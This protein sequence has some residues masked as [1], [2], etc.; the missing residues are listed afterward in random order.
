MRLVCCLLTFLV[1]ML[2]VILGSRP[3]VW[4]SSSQE[5]FL[6]G[7]FRG[8][9]LTSDGRLVQ[10]PQ[11]KLMFNTAQPFIYAVD[12]DQQGNILAGTGSEGK[13]YRVTPNGQGAELADFEQ[14]GVQALAVRPDGQVLAGTAPDG[15]VYRIAANGSVSVFFDPEEKYIWDLTLDPAGALFVATG[16]RGRIFKVNGQGRGEVFYDSSEEHIVD[17]TWDAQG[18]LLAGSSPAGLLISLNQ[19]GK[20]FVLFDSDLEEVRAINTDRYGNIY[21]VAISFSKAPPDPAETS[22]QAE[23][24]PGSAAPADPAGQETV[25]IEGIRKGSKIELFRVARDNLVDILYSAADRT[26]FDLLV[27]QNGEVLMGSGPQGRLLSITAAR[28][29]KVLGETPDEQVT[30]LVSA[31]NRITVAT[32]NLGK[33]YRL[34]REPGT[35]G[36]YESDVLDAG[37]VSE[38]GRIRWQVT[39]PGGDGIGFST[40]SGN[41]AKADDTWSEWAGVGEGA[42]GTPV[43]SPAARYLQWMVEFANPGESNA[44]LSERNGIDSVEVS[45]L[46]KN[47][48]PQITSVSV[49][50]PGSAFVKIPVATQLNAALGGPDDSH[51]RSLPP[52]IRSL[53]KAPV[54]PPRRIYTP[55]SRSVTWKATDRNGDDLAF[56]IYLRGK[57]DATWRLLKESWQE[58]FY[59]LDAAS[60]PDGVYTFRIV[61]SDRFS[62]P[63]GKAL[64]TEMISK[65]FTVANRLPTL[66]IGEP[67]VSEDGAAFQV[68]AKTHTSSVFQLEYSLDGRAWV[69][70]WPADGIADSDNE[71]YEIELSSLPQGRHS[72]LIR[73]IDSVGNL[74]SG[75]VGFTVR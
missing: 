24:P 42:T 34:S 41:T 48:A 70:A 26:V 39:R 13:L 33:L 7:T 2:P 57:S 36:T 49:H 6:K 50:A 27:R 28:L 32:S 10:A 20:P 51:L 55:A 29:K 61:A 17:L 37:V 69:I 1:A 73:V 11:I 5:D 44:L 52:S 47:I 63:P 9:A 12:V 75:S 60:V 68:T 15:K 30:R 53:K 58:T 43:P 22:T 19:S 56:D 59:T 4:R 67:R 71:T 25:Q 35:T 64:E 23:K 45:Y 46:Q 62:N 31:A 74:G 65:P 18:N 8:V 40:R 14:P 66:E 72:L 16:P 3:T 54:V 38:W 21:A